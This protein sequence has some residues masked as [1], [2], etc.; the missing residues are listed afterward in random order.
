MTIDRYQMNQNVRLLQNSIHK[1]GRRPR[2]DSYYDVVVERRLNVNMNV[3]DGVCCPPYALLPPLLH[4]P[5]LSLHQPIDAR[6]ATFI[7]TTI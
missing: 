7:Y 5:A 4:L 1:I 3:Y 6:C 2:N